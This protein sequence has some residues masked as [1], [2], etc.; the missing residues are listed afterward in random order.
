MSATL[1]YTMRKGFILMSAVLL[2][3]SMSPAQTVD[4][5]IAKNL[6]AKGGLAK[7]KAVQSI[8]ITGTMDNGGLQL[9][10]VQIWKRPNKLR[11]ELSLPGFTAVQAYDGQTGWQVNPMYGESGPASLIGSHL[12]E[13]QEEADIDGPLVDYK[14]K[15][16][17][18]ELIGN[19][20][21]DATDTYHLRITLK[22]GSVS[23]VYLDAGSF[24]E[25]KERRKSIHPGPERTRET[26]F[27]DYKQVQGMVLPFSIDAHDLGFDGPGRKM[28]VEK[29]EFDVPIDDAQFKI[30]PPG[31]TP[32]PE[33]IK[34]GGPHCCPE[35]ELR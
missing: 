3:A 24:L 14:L 5:I 34:K 8:T 29:V 19:E 31:P 13:I 21:I 33:V 10:V 12:K 7:I 28:L 11:T 17:K 1:R 16:H 4:E 20:T 30:P 22:D 32:D 26:I 18:V 9:T 15:G 2:L 6:A 23:D 27:G 35:S 25:I